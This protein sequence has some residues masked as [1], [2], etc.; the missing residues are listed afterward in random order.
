M[1]G[2]AW[3]TSGR[4]DQLSISSES[5]PE[6]HRLEVDRLVTSERQ[7]DGRR[8]TRGRLVS[9]LRHPR[10]QAH[11]EEPMA[12]DPLHRGWLSDTKP[13][14]SQLR[15][16]AQRRPAQHLQLHG[17]DMATNRARRDGVDLVRPLERPGDVHELRACRG[18]WLQGER[19][20]AG[21]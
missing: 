16:L 21:S 9:D 7:S 14:G 10:P 4:G 17:P 11:T 13:D 2:P 3:Q 15:G 5:H 1:T 20:R 19:R 12:S 18:D 6:P 8:H